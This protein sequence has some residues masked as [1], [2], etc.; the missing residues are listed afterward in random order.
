MSGN[1]NPFAGAQT[2]PTNDLQA[3]IADSY[4]NDFRRLY[5][6][7]YQVC[8]NLP[9][10]ADSA[11]DMVNDA[12]IKAL[13]GDWRGDST[14]YTFLFSCTRNGALDYIRRHEN[15]RR[16]R[17]RSATG[18]EAVP[19]T[20]SRWQ[21]SDVTPRPFACPER[22]YLSKER[23]ELVKAALAQFCTPREAA[24]WELCKLDG[25]TTTDAAEVAGVS[26]PTA[27]R[28][29]AAATSKISAHIDAM[30]C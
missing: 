19:H 2:M 30:T 20:E 21:A 24:V 14:L 7:A 26:Q 8:R 11:R 23:R 3:I 18:P 12:Y 28:A 25:M 15:S 9:D 4:K 17:S 10:A 22:S 13:R 6:C 5:F 16:L 1:S 27:H 29:L